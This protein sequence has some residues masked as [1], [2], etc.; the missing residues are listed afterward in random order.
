MKP[1]L[2]LKI[3][4]IVFIVS[5]F[6]FSTLSYIHIRTYKE[7]METSFVNRASSIAQSLD[8]GIETK[9]DIED[10]ETLLLLIQKQIW[11][12]PDILDI[13]IN[14]FQEDILK[15]YLSSDLN[16]ID[17]EAEKINFESYTQDMILNKITETEKARVLTVVT[18]IHVS[19]K[20]VGTYQIDIT[21]EN[22]DK[23]INRELQTTL[24]TFFI[25]LFLFILILFFFLKRIIVNP[26]YTI[27]EGF[28]AVKKDKLDFRVNINSN[29]EIGVL[30]D[31]FNQMIE[32]LA[33][34]RKQLKEYSRNL[35]KKV[36]ER[37]K[38]L[39]KRDRELIKINKK[40]EEANQKLMKLD[41]EKNEFI[42]I[43]AHE[44]KTPLTS[45]KG[46]AQLMNT[47]KVMKDKKKLRH[48]LK[49]VNK[50]TIRLYNI[51]LDIVDSSRL[52]LGKLNLDIEEV[53]IRK[54]FNEVKNNMK[55]VI[56]EGGIEPVFEL[57]ENLPKIRV[58]PGRLLQVI[59]NLIV[60]ATHFTSRGGKIS[61]KVHKKNNKFVQFEVKDTG[62]GIPK[63][64]QDKIFSRFYQ[65]D[66]SLSRKV[67]GSGLGLSIC[68][69]LVELMGGKI[70]FESKEGKG[71]TF[72]FTI[73][74]S[75]C[76]K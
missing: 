58:D 65:V 12:D 64:K 34:S 1:R 25:L 2:Q 63:D 35:E 40:L 69:G 51:I 71:T 17:Q 68:K 38:E 23:K 46:F 13:N 4:G 72:Y 74:T 29:D 75:N 53:D 3:I 43:A 19:G 49:L 9:T 20:I 22:I 32:I 45:I 67:K 70:W 57:E 52:S 6:I 28:E 8:A 50:N 44:L 18:P 66:A 11:L 76:L 31:S 16:K 36:K 60:N 33:A 39:E 5:F 15:V 27:N 26:I 21:L 47:N 42:S 24:I 37:T 54:I 55:I 30:A 14:L 56:K 7:D 62:E 59:R 41:K 10:R 61:F 73:P 48:Y